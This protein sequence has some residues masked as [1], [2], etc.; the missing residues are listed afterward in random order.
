MKTAPKRGYGRKPK[1]FPLE[2]VKNSATKVAQFIKMGMTMTDSARAAG[3]N[4][5][6]L[7][8]WMEKA[9]AG[10]EGYDEVNEILEN[11]RAIGQAVLVQRVIKASE[12]DWKAAGWILERRHRDIWGKPV[13]VNMS[14]SLRIGEMSDEELDAELAK[15]RAEAE[16]S[17]GD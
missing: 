13:D 8:S 4:P 12:H 3:V 17:N 7:F 14:G 6:T 9:K 15:A 10:Q 5:R 2:E 11:A 16:A 1:G